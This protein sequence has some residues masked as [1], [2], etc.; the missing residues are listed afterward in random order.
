MD[1]RRS[2]GVLPEAAGQNLS[3]QEFSVPVS[4]TQLSLTRSFQVPSA[5]LDAAFTVKVPRTSSALSL[6]L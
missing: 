1:H 6:A 3:D 5:G 4:L 2:G